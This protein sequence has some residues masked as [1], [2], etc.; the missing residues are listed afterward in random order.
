MFLQVFGSTGSHVVNSSFFDDKHRSL[1]SAAGGYLSRSSSL[2][3]SH[4]HLPPAQ[5]LEN[6]KF[7]IDNITRWG[8]KSVRR[9]GDRNFNVLHRFTKIKIIF[10]RK[11]YHSSKYLIPGRTSL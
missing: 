4:N 5:E 10:Y 2:A 7:S 8:A 3:S 9:V 11:T 1:I 6:G